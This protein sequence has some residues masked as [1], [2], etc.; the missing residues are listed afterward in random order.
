LIGYVLLNREQ[1][2]EVCDA[3][4]DDS[5]TGDDNINFNLKKLEQ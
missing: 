1:N 4:D 3:R 5:N 2:D